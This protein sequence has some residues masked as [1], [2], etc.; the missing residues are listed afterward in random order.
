VLRMCLQSNV[1]KSTYHEVKDVGS[2]SALD[3]L[4]VSSAPHERRRVMHRVR[5]QH[6]LRRLSGCNALYCLVSVGSTGAYWKW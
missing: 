2:I 4:I 3:L 6:I 5:C 1:L